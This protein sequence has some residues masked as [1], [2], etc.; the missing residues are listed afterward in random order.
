M[1]I[2]EGMSPPAFTLDMA[3]VMSQHAVNLNKVSKTN[4]AVDTGMS[5]IGYIPSNEA[6]EENCGNQ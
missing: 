3:K 5:R 2:E 1:V 4:I 6:A